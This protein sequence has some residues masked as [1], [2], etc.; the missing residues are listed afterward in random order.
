M[1]NK[2]VLIT[3][4][5]GQLGSNICSFFMKKKAHVF[6]TDLNKD[7]IINSSG[8]KIYQ[9][10]KLLIWMLHQKNLLTVYRSSSK[11]YVSTY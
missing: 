2:N 7:K 3:G 11:E 1:K 8:I 5:A 4:A 10:F 9:I 6:A